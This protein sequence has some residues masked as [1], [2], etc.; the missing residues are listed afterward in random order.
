MFRLSQCPRRRVRLAEFEDDFARLGYRKLLLLDRQRRK[1]RNASALRRQVGLLVLEHILEPRD[2]TREVLKVRV[3]ARLQGSDLLKDRV[4]PQR[5]RA[6][7]GAEL[8]SA[9]AQV[10]DL[11]VDVRVD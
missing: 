6:V 5:V 7:L 1:V 3:V 8:V 2:T 4:D 10:L 9:R 11:R